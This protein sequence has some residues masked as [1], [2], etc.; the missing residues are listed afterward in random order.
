MKRSSFGSHNNTN[1]TKEKIAIS[2]CC[3][4]QV[5]TV[6]QMT[7]ADMLS[8]IKPKHWCSNCNR[9]DCT[10]NWEPKYEEISRGIYRLREIRMNT[11]PI[12]SEV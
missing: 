12:N 2:E 3:G 10:I 8:G 11:P 6:G 5:L 7:I 9:E 4:A 1:D